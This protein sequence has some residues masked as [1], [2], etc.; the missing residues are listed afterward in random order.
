MG[1]DMS[2]FKEEEP[3]GGAHELGKKPDVGFDDKADLRAGGGVQGKWETKVQY[4]G[5]CTHDCK[6][7]TRRNCP[8]RVE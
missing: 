6:H 1:Y 8:N 4:M 2:D 3:I 5:D 7:C